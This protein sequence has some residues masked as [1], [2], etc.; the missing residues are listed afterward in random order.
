MARR[1]SATPLEANP[2]ASM[3][4]AADRTMGEGPCPAVPPAPAE[5]LPT[6]TVPVSALV[7]AIWTVWLVD[8]AGEDDAGADATVD[9]LELPEPLPEPLPEDSDLLGTVTVLVGPGTVTV[10]VGLGTVTVGPGTVTVW[11]AGSAGGG[12]VVSS[13]A[14]ATAVVPKALSAS[15]TVV[16]AVMSRLC[17]LTPFHL[18]VVSAAG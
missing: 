18:V 9:L 10:W 14:R 11:G 16:P 17:M 15:A 7:S 8:V 3:A 13:P 6:G 12:V 2:S 1:F 5:T 4:R